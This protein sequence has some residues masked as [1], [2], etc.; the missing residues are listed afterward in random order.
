YIYLKEHYNIDKKSTVVLVGSGNN[1]GDGLVVARKIYESGGEV[2]VIM[3]NSLPSTKEAALNYQRIKRS[4]IKIV[5]TAF[6]ESVAKR[7][8]IN[9]D[10]II[11]AIVG[12]GLHSQLSESISD[13][14]TLVN[15]TVAKRIALDVPTGL[16]SDGDKYPTTYFKAE[17]TLAF[18]AKKPVHTQIITKGLCGEVVVLDIGISDLIM[19][20]VQ[21]NITNVD[22]ELVKDFLPIRSDHSNKSTFGKV[23]NIAGSSNFC[24]AAAISTMAALRSGAG[25]VNLA[26][27]KEV[28]SAIYPLVFEATSATLEQN[29]VGTISSNA[30]ETISK[31]LKK[32][33]A[34]LIGCGIGV[35]EDTIMVLEKVITSAKC[36]LV[37]DADALNCLALH[38]E[39]LSFKNSDIILT[40]HIG[41]MARL[42][43]LS[44][45]YIATNQEEVA[46]KFAQEYQVNVVLKSEVTIIATCDKEIFR[47]SNGNSSLAKGGS[48]DTLAGI[49]VALLAQGLPPKKAC[50]CASFILGL[51][52]Q[53]LVESGSAYAIIARDI[54][55]ELPKTF[56][57]LER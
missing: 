15:N 47:N 8:I 35:N 5:D 39:F 4:N 7:Y 14:I 42:T 46:I 43:G 36:P 52:A 25:I 18:A 21:F 19:Q 55:N 34:C 48:G 56:K 2:V 3:C 13:V 54:I 32:A 27:T 49:I 51:S 24:G 1:G 28:L 20:N 45:D 31:H 50:V 16:Q 9:S 23:L 44:A 53:M 12:T 38:K 26:A 37:I 29:E 41:E 33:D 6:E 40:P 30:T 10:I 17:V 11:D 57:L 22:N